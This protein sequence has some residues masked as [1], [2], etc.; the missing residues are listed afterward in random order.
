[1]L[2]TWGRWPWWGA[3][4]QRGKA[5]CPAQCR[6][7]T[8]LGPG[9]TRGTPGPPITVQ[10]NQS[11][12]VDNN[13]KALKMLNAEYKDFMVIPVA[14]LGCC[15]EKSWLVTCQS[16]E[17]LGILRWLEP[18]YVLAR[19]SASSV[20]MKAPPGAVRLLMFRIWV[21]DKAGKPQAAAGA[22]IKVVVMM[23]LVQDNRGWRTVR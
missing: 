10:F 19:S 17:C 8:T 14:C 1:M 3:T 23:G 7:T 12:I 16:W 9:T 6:P 21:Q 4:C 20:S 22:L 11:Q 2:V 13:N 5:W 15:W 18:F